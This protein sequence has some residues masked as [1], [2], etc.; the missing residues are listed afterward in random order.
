MQPLA[1]KNFTV[2]F[3]PQTDCTLSIYNIYTDDIDSVRAASFIICLINTL[4]S[5]VA[6]IGN[7]LI[8]L[9]VVRTSALHSPSN[10]LLCCLAITDFLTGLVTQP[11]FVCSVVARIAKSYDLYCTASLLSFLPVYILSGVSFLTLTAISID[12]FIALRIHLRYRA[13]VTIRRVLSIEAGVWLFSISVTLLPFAG[14]FSSF[15]LFIAL[16]ISTSLTLNVSAYFYILHTLR[17]HKAKI[18]NHDQIST[19]YEKAV[20]VRKVKSSSWTMLAVFCLFFAC[21]IPTL[22]V[23]ITG[24]AVSTTKPLSPRLRTIRDAS[25]TLVLVNSSLN[26]FV[27]CYRMTEIRKAVC[28]TVSVWNC[29]GK[30]VQRVLSTLAVRTEN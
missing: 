16:I 3:R 13:I 14:F 29:F 7:L 1:N 22:C 19:T 23:M 8:I 18:A 9:S 24:S 20:N 11:L 15:Q 26:P 10:V 5:I 4:S 30:R 2:Y 6:V 21:Y 12:R 28:A 25:A 27:Y 17:K